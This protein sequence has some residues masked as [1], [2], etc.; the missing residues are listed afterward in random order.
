MRNCPLS[1]LCCDY[2]TGDNRPPNN[3]IR[4][5]VPCIFFLDMTCEVSILAQE[6]V[7]GKPVACP[8]NK[9]RKER[10]GNK[11]RTI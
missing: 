9:G 4:V 11:N 2:S 1:D 3:H 5:F 8:I 6:K 10:D 7:S